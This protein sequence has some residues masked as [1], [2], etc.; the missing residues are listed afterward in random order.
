MKCRPPSNRIP[1]PEERLSCR[2]YLLKQIEI[3]DPVIIILLGATALQGL[4]DPEAKITKARGNWLQW[5]GIS[6]M[7]TYHPAASAA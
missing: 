7:P 2:A 4:I 6:V 3:I 5:Q 1:T